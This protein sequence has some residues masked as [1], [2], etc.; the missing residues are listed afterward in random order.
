MQLQAGWP[1]HSARSKLLYMDSHCRL[2]SNRRQFETICC[3][4]ILRIF[5]RY[6]IIKASPISNNKIYESFKI[7]VF[8]FKVFELCQSLVKIYTNIFAITAGRLCRQARQ[9]SK[10]KASMHGFSWS[11]VIYSQS[12]WDNL[13]WFHIQVFPKILS[14]LFKQ[15][16]SKSDFY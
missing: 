15:Y 2:S 7:S 4:F 9:L 14:C 3:P 10:G 1:R 11:S 12:V 5:Q 13:L 8:L 6:L 16:Y